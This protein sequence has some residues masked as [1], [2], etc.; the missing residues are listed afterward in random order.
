MELS[1]ITS[2]NGKLFIHSLKEYPDAKEE[3]DPNFPLSFGPIM[4]TTFLVDSDHGH[5]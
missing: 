5:D 2:E 3:L 1:R 4:E